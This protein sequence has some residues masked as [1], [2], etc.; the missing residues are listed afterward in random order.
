MT[1]VRWPPGREVTQKVVL[2]AL[3]L[4]T[5]IG[6]AVPLVVLAGLGRFGPSNVIYFTLFMVG[7]PAYWAFGS[8]IVLRVNGN[9]VGWL[10]AIGA[11]LSVA[12]FASYAVG[13]GLIGGDAPPPLAAWLLIF[14]AATFIPALFLVMLAV[15]ITFPTGSLPGPRWRRPVRLV[16]AMVAGAVLGV[17]ARPGAIDDGLPDNPAA[18]WFPGLP[19]A[20]L[21]S[22]DALGQLALGIGAALGIL[23]IVSRFRRAGRVERQQLKLFAVAIIPTT[24]VLPLSL[25]GTPGDLA[26]NLSR[27]RSAE[28]ARITDILTVVD[29]TLFNI[30]VTVAILRYRLYDIDRIVSRTISYGVVTAVLLATFLLANLALQTLLSSFTSNNALAVAGST[31]LA[32][33]LFTPVR[34]RVQR[35]VDRRFNRAQYDAER[36]AVAF[37]ERLRDQVDLPELANELAATVRQAIAPSSVGLW[38]RRVDGCGLRFATSPPRFG[39]RPSPRS[40]WSRPSSV[41]SARSPCV[42]LT[43]YPCCPARL[44]SVTSRSSGSRSWASRSPRLARCWWSVGPGT[45]SAGAWS[46][47]AS[48]TRTAGWPRP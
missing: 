37:S 29:L 33:A 35:T 26:A 46:S 19:T 18:S 16:A 1:G 3:G 7:L 22:L 21:D 36:T 32:A 39:R 8:L 40:G 5:V 30:A 11:A 38:L 45:P 47:S 24:I 28:G 12:S 14:G 43:R 42:C 2:G 34:L 27:M 31:L 41:G 48:A 9:T 15:F 6:S 25:I 20:A 13:L 17:V 44:V 4:V 23:A 10:M